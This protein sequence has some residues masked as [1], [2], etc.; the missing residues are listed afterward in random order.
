MATRKLI[1]P[2]PD[3]KQNQIESAHEPNVEIQQSL[4][5]QDHGESGRLHGTHSTAKILELPTE[6]LYDVL[7]YLSTEDLV[8][9]AFCRWDLFQALIGFLESKARPSLR[10]LGHLVTLFE[11]KWPQKWLRIIVPICARSEQPILRDLGTIVALFE[12]SH[13]PKKQL[14]GIILES[15]RHDQPAVHS[16]VEL[17]FE[18]VACRYL[19]KSPHALFDTNILHMTALH[20]SVLKGVQNVVQEIGSIVQN[21]PEFDRVEFVNRHDDIQNTPLDYA[22]TTSSSTIA[23]MLI[24]AGARID[25]TDRLGFTPLMNAC[26][27]GRD[28]VVHCLVDRGANIRATNSFNLSVL[29]C[30]VIGESRTK[31]ALLQRI[32]PHATQVQLNRALWLAVND[33]KELVG[34]LLRFGA[35]GQYAGILEEA[36]WYDAER[37]GHPRS[38]THR[39]VEASIP[40]SRR[41][42]NPSMASGFMSREPDFLADLNPIM[43]SEASTDDDGIVDGF[44]TF[45]RSP[46]FIFRYGP[47]FAAKFSAKYADGHDIND[48]ENVSR[49]DVRITQLR[50]SNDRG[51]HWRY[52]KDNV[53]GICA[54]AFEERKSPDKVYKLRRGV[55][56][57]IKWRNIMTVDQGLLQGNCS[58]IP[59]DDFTRLCGSKNLAESKLREG[60]RRQEDRFINWKHRDESQASR[61]RRIPA[62][63]PWDLT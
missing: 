54:V 27:L 62:P 15:A 52:S 44:G 8:S 4:Q 38:T 29:E 10:N 1:S 35:D 61:A 13:W 63:F 5:R 45:R 32:C 31:E 34:I 43:H 40:L 11:G 59:R 30:I 6:L 37:N 21:M 49:F 12:D 56:V 48:R 28:E 23:N 51:R 39:P 60:W 17:G 46:I 14:Q 25:D 3:T 57:K 53:L 36:D 18:E 55:W 20:I 22:I 16:C 9:F 24:S 33:K 50:D 42:L 41:H 47:D 7:D 58:W 26:H 19:R 2:M